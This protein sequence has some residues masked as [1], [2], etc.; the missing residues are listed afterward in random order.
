[1]ATLLGDAEETKETKG[2]ETE[3][4][5]YLDSDLKT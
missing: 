5:Q 3:Y 1:M 4:K 2:M